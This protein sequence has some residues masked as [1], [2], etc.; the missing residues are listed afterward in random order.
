MYYENKYI[1]ED[2]EVYDEK[3]K[4]I[5]AVAAGRK[6]ESSQVGTQPRT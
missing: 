2:F 4:K 3:V 1:F 5:Y 6:Q